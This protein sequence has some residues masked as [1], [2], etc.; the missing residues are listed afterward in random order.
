M[1]SSVPLQHRVPRWRG[2]EGLP[3][4]L[5]ATKR[6]CLPLPFSTISSDKNFFRPLP[7]FPSWIAVISPTAVAVDVNRCRARSFSLYVSES[8]PWA[9][10]VEFK[11]YTRALVDTYSLFALSGDSNSSHRSAFSSFA[12]SVNLNRQKPK[13]VS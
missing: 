4:L 12:V 3:S 11:I 6:G 8:R 7:S 9:K 1:G 13:A 2:C 10:A 5:S